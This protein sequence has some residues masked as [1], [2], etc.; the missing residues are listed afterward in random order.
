[1]ERIPLGKTGITV[2]RLAIGTGTNGWAGSSDQTRKGFSWLVE[3][4]R[5]GYELGAAFWDL[6][7]QYGSHPH[8]KEALKG[9]DRSQV[10]IL[11]KTTAIG[12][13]EMRS[14]MERFLR[15][16]GTDRIDILL[17]HAKS[18]SEWNRS[19][20]GAMEA[21]AEAKERGAVRAVGISCHGLGALKTAAEEPWLDVIL[22][23]LNYAGINMDAPPEEVIPVLRRLTEKGK[24]VLAMKVLGRGPL[25]GDP[26]KAIKFVLEL[27]CVHA[28]TIGHESHRQLEENVQTIERLEREARP[29]TG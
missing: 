29:C 24:G 3:H 2:P 22:V 18:S 8:A 19:C 16:L 13:D 21:L 23:R 10:V 9:I 12:Y 6:A 5:L 1:M 11:T 20:R 25:T 14:A 26:E 7:D 4:L 15:E 17:L 28:M 27:G